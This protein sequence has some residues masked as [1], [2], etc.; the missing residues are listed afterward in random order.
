MCVCVFRSLTWGKNVKN[1]V[2][3]QCNSCACVYGLV[4]MPPFREQGQN[5]T[6]VEI[7]R[8]K[9]HFR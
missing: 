6:K 1:R 5:H 9:A 3:Y 7:K 8:S 2:R 4:R